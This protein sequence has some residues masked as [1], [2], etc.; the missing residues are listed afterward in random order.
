MEGKRQ[1]R[2]D[3]RHD[4]IMKEYEIVIKDLGD[5]IAPYFLRRRIYEIIADKLHYSVEHVQSV[6]LRRLRRKRTVR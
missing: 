1:S 2:A 3:E 4:D 6:V 5:N